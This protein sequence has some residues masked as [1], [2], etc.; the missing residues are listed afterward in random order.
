MSQEKLHAGPAKGGRL[1]IDMLINDFGPIKRAAVSLRPLTIFVGG[2]GTGKSY[3]AM[4]AH[5]VMSAGRGLDRLPSR[6]PA[7]SSAGIR[8]ILAGLEKAVLAL[9]SKDE[10]ECP[11]RLVARIRRSCVDEYRARLERE[12]ARNFGSD[13]PDLARS[14]AGHFS[15][16]L[17]SGG[18]A[19]MSYKKGRLTLGSMPK[20]GIAFRSSRAADLSGSFRLGWSGDRRLCC[21]IGDGIAG[22]PDVRGLLESLY[23]GLVSTMLRRAAAALPLSSAHIPAARSGILQAHRVIAPSV[24]GRDAPAGIEDARAPLLPGAASDLVSAMAGMS[25]IRGAHG[26][27]GRQIEGDIL[28]GR[29]RLEHADPGALLEMFYDGPGTA[30][31]MHRASSAALELAPLTLH[32]RHRAEARS[33]LIIE[34]PEAH[35][36]PRSQGLLAGHIVGLVREGASIVITT[37]SSALFES[38]SQY[39]RAGRLPPKG[40]KSA[41]G[42]EDLYLAEDEVAPHLFRMDGDGGSV[43]ERIAMSATDGIEQE[44]FVKEDRLLNEVNLRIEEEHAGPSPRPAR[45]GWWHRR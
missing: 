2:N 33:V 3:A 12:V 19:V 38:I 40:R 13:L 41:L 20:F 26:R 44:E 43:V 5:S 25:P 42:R 36:H 27:A 34:E 16:A 39:L 15:V 10:I 30:V 17:R 24:V 9:K 22:L 31:P 14:G 28:G 8:D 11:P 37:H 6:P 7:R 45:P 35:L 23:A 21:S 4:L 18:R 29:V 32:L 1:N